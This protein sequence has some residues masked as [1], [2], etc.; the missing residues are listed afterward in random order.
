MTSRS[1]GRGGYVCLLIAA[2]FVSTAAA[3]DPPRPVADEFR[4]AMK[5]LAAS[6]VRAPEAVN[7]PAC[8]A[9]F[10]RVVI[11]ATSGNAQPCIDELEI[12][13]PDGKTNLAL[14]K[15]GAVAS[16]SSLLPGYPIHQIA[17]LND[18]RYGN[19]HS[20]IA[21][22]NGSEWVQIELPKAAS[23]TS[24]VITRDREGKFGDR[25]AEVFDVMVSKDGKQWQVVAKRERS[26]PNR[27]RHLPMF[28]VDRLPEKSWDG[29]L[30][31][32]FA[33][34]RTTWS[35][36]PADDH[37]SPLLV[38]R[39]AEP[40]GSPYW[41][42]LARLAPLER[43]LVL[44]DDMIERLARSGL[45][46]TQERAE[47]ASLR[48]RAAEQ[49]NSEELYLAAR[50][51]KRQLF[52]RDPALADIATILFAKRN[53]YLE[54]HNYSEHLDGILEPGGGVF[55]LRIPRDEQKRFRPERASIQRLFDGSEG[56]ARE[57]V[58]DYDAS[59][60]Y[61]AYR[62][63]KAEVD[64][65]ASYWHL[66]AMNADGSGVR[67]LTNGPFHDF[68]AVC[69]PDGGLAFNSTRCKVRFLCWRP[70]A[71]VLY[72]MEADG[73]DIRRLSFANLSEWKPSMMQNGRVL[74]TRSE[75]LD[76]GADFGHTLWSIRPDGTHPELVFGNNTPNCYSQAHEV[77]GTQEI[78]CTL[79][80]HGDHSGPVALLD[81]DKGS[82]RHRGHHQYHPGHAAAVP[83]EPL[84]QRYVPRSLSD[85]AGSFPRGP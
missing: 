25:T 70:Q 76:K 72:R 34:E 52:F 45:D 84:A 56:I 13:G 7:F 73:S 78:V 10:V 40:G 82:V 67:K 18:G 30:R 12:Y 64:G 42:R 43:V 26:G 3:G 48:R 75:Y 83:D 9:R 62:P 36:I 4:D 1:I 21:A 31:Y 60:I 55:V 8:E 50:R 47:A 22:T 66:Y 51:A 24:V 57:P 63:D 6:A 65:W 27:A 68:D 5:R 77:P 15:G 59:R 61:F 19:D 80:S 53:P 35:H 11:H 20:W 29:Y 81:R 54:S 38:D 37:L 44:M 28:A 41:G 69:L 14:A 85:F 49:P 39:P 2:G 16:A 32:A 23:I 46:V 58:A 74:W 17:H 71:Y 79:M 33:R